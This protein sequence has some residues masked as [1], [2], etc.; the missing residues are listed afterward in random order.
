MKKTNAKPRMVGGVNKDP[1]LRVKTKMLPA[2]SKKTAREIIEAPE[3][4][5]P[6]ISKL[7]TK[8][9]RSIFGDNAESI[10]QLIEANDTDSAM[11]LIYKK[12]LQTLLDL[13]PYAEHA[14]RKS[15]G[16]RGVYQINS[17]I[18][19]MRELMVDIQSSQDRGMM[20]QALM[21]NVIKPTFAD[22]ANSIVQE[23]GMIGA[24][25]KLGMTDK[26]WERFQVSLKASRSR[27]ADSINRQYGE[28]REQTISY[29]QR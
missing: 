28:I 8:G 5:L 10:M 19:S 24:D 22:L 11:S 23:Y 26:E 3:T 12:S 13:L 16:A 18:S 4:K 2:P 25:A 29:L 15:K 21:E 7:N 17:L 20:G 6:R 1:S 27:L 14:I 9:M